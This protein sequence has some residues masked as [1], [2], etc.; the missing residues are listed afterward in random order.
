METLL[1]NE[2]FV[3]QFKYW[4]DGQIRVGMRFRS[5]LFESVSQFK[6]NQRPQAFELAWQ[7]DQGGKEVV[8]TASPTQYTVWVNLKVAG[9]TGLF[10]NRLGLSPLLETTN[11][12]TSEIVKQPVLS[13]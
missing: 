5:N 1:I 7:L 13:A 2:Q 6:H 12:P 8:V 9:N 4:R 10:P 11:Q 3:F